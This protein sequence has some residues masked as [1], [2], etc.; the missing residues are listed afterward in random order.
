[1]T[2]ATDAAGA[3]HLDGLQAGRECLES[4]LACLGRGWCPLVVCP[5]DHVGVGKAHSRAC[6]SPGKA[7]LVKWLDFQERL[8]T[9]AEV[10]GWWKHWPNANVGCVLG[11]VSGMARVDVDGPGGEARLREISGGDLLDTLEFTSGR[12]N[13]GRG[14]LY[15]IPAGVELRTAKEA[16]GDKQELRFQ[17]AGA[18]TVL[19]PSRHPSGSRYAWK[20]GHA[21]GELALAPAPPWLLEQLR[22]AGR[23]KSR[24]PLADG[25][26]IGQGG[27]NDALLSLAGSMRRRGMSEDAIAAA[28]LVENEARC[29]PPLPEEEVQAIARSVT[30][31]KPAAEER[32]GHAEPGG[33]DG[34]PPPEGKPAPPGG[35]KPA[36][37]VEAID[38][39][40]RLARLFVHERC[41]DGGR[42][43][44]RSWRE[45]WHRWDGSAYRVLAEKELRAGLTQSAKAEMDRANLI[46][47]KL[48][49]KEDKPVPAARK[50]TGRLIADVAHALVSL[51]I[52]PSRA[53]AP[54]W[55]DGE[56][57]FPAPEILACRNGLVHLPSLVAGKDHLLPPTPRFFSG[58]CLDYDFDLGAPPAAGWLEFLGK[59]W[60]DDAE[61]IATLQ[62]WLGYLL[63]PDTRQQKIL[64]L[65]GPKRSGKG[66]IARV[67]TALLG[68]ENVAGPTLSSLGTNFGL[69]PLLGKSAAVVSDARLSG[70]TDSATVTERLLSISGEDS[71]TID[72]KHLPPVTTKLAA[73]FTILTNEL[74]RLGDTSGALAGRM[75]VLR[76]VESW[77]GREDTRLTDR[78]LGEL[79][80]ILLWAIAGWQRFGGRGHFVQPASGKDLLSELEDITSP[81]GAFVR[82]CC[83]VGPGL[84]VAFDTLFMAWRSWCE[85]HGRREPGLREIFGRDLLAAAPS[86]RKVRPREGEERYRGY[87][88]IGMRT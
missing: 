62:E 83:E 5:P 28:L 77:Y 25:E 74:P 85:S 14:L 43:V 36:R 33:G 35:D 70:R 54:A 34:S 82:E 78:L 58:N 39:P 3:A 29:R 55:L 7:P 68:R 11:P 75:I 53:D 79:P 73:R 87:E 60:P 18:Q 72:R 57:P 71:L 13:G 46:A 40:H 32:N 38:D 65:V 44:L 15:A 17:A 41:K 9:E 76:L 80:G 45:E 1:M 84:R 59:L 69:W 23:G 88:G 12:E 21:P 86:I 8:P 16:R 48:A 4:A 56:G 20:T 10:R 22:P 42:L 64:L 67:L 2:T 50:V 66:T 37:V 30:R 81:V 51:T 26:V 27:R 63:T 52:L 19:P 24:Q 6:K 31:Y 47:Q 49:E 61:S